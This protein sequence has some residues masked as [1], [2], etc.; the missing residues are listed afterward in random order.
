MK[1][2][3][4]TNSLFP[5]RSAN[6]VNT[7]RLCSELA[8]QGVKVT[9]IIPNG[10]ESDQEIFRFYDL[11]PTFKIRQISLFYQGR[12]A[13][14]LRAVII[15]LHLRRHKY[16]AIYGRDTVSF[17]VATKLGCNIVYDA[18]KPAQIRRGPLGWLYRTFYQSN[19]LKGVSVISN[20]LRSMYEEAGVEPA[21]LTLIR[22]ASH[23]L[24]K[25]DIDT[26]PLNRKKITI[27]YFGHLFYGRGIDVIL[28]VALQ[29]ADYHFIIVGGTEKDISEW[30]GKVQSEN[31]EFTGYVQPTQVGRWLRSCQILL[32]PY[33]RSL[34][35]WGGK[36]DS[37]AYMSPIKIFE[38]MSSRIPMV[39]SDLPIL[40]EILDDSMAYFCVP[41]EAE[42]W[43]EKILAIAADQEAAAKRAE[44]AYQVYLANYTWPK[45]T[46]KVLQ[47][48]DQSALRP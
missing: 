29:L 6:T 30:R 14:Y 24:A 41:E 9:L 48:F 18:H 28:E 7:M 3:Y 15:A 13:V 22:N 47:L 23:P 17:S 12:G 21:K 37:A 16:N 27:G 44:Q 19:R 42:S 20:K 33:Q 11:A 34:A 43:K 39:V 4:V 1:L 38:Y 31:V 46:A 10:G 8:K 32:A 45:R 2:A 26:E 40:R 5:S 35:V 25:Y 36:E